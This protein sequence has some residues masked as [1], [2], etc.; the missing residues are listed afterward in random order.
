M[1]YVVHFVFCTVT[2]IFCKILKIDFLKFIYKFPR[3]DFSS[4]DS[5]FQKLLRVFH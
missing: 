2:H 1:L 5:I 4:K 3:F